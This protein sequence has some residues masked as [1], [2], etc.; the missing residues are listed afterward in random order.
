MMDEKCGF[1]LSENTE[2]EAVVGQENIEVQDDSLQAVMAEFTSLFERFSNE[3]G[4]NKDLVMI[5]LI[6]IALDKESQFHS[7][8]ELL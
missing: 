3:C 4:D 8:I 2:L 6:Q 7:L 1:D 5:K